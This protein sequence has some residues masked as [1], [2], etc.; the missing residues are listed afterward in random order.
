MKNRYRK[1]FNSLK[2]H[3]EFVAGQRSELLFVDAADVCYRDI[4]AA[5]APGIADADS[6]GPPN[7][8]YLRAGFPALMLV[9]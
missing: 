6:T 1:P 4:A 8:V 9:L 5:A 7:R 3:P 2:R